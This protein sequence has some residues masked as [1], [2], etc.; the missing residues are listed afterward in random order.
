ML[1]IP[2]FFQTKFLE[3]M[4][5]TLGCSTNASVHSPNCNVLF[6]CYVWCFDISTAHRA[7]LDESAHPKSSDELVAPVSSDEFDI[8]ACC[9][10]ATNLPEGT[11]TLFLEN[12]TEL[13]PVDYHIR[14][15]QRTN[16]NLTL[17]YCLKQ[18]KILKI[19]LGYRLLKSL[20][21]IASSSFSSAYSSPNK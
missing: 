1:Y 18:L 14:N 12:K 16:F 9:I 10:N 13:Y 6:Q 15:P 11:F 21:G 2:Y 20:R 3:H 8:R 19:L 7:S 5:I 17:T 4:W